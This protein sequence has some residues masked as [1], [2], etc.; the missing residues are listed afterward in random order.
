MSTGTCT[1]DGCTGTVLAD[2]YCDTCGTP[3][4]VAAP[5]SATPPA[6]AATPPPVTGGSCATPDCAGTILD[7]GYC[8]T[9]GTLASASAATGSTRTSSTRSTS[10]AVSTVTGTAFTSGSAMGSRRTSRAST[11]TSSRRTGIGE[12]LVRVPTV[13]PIDPA[14]VVMKDPEVAERKRFCSNCGNK[15]GRGRKDEPGRLSGFCSRCRTAFDFVPKL[16][17]GDLVGGQYEVAGCLAHG[18]LGWIYLA[19]DTAVSGRWVVLKGLLNSG[20][21]AAMA[22]AVAERRF[23]AEVQ[24]PNIVEIYNFATHEGAGYTVMEYV[25]GKSLNQILKARRKAA[26][27]SADPLPVSE[28]IA[29]ML[30][31]APAMSY[32]HDKGLLYCDFKPDNVLQ[33]GDGV[34][35]IDLGGVRRID[36]HSADIYGTVGFQ[37]PEIAEMGPTIASDVFTVGRALAVLTMDFRG[38]TSEYVTTLPPAIDH[39]ALA[40]NDAFHRV[41]QKATAP[42]PDDRFQSIEEL[43]DQLL[44]VLRI[45]VAI[46]SGVPQP[47]P[48]A[49][50]TGAPLGR[51]LPGLS[52]DADDDAAGFLSTLP[53]DPNEAIDTIA[54]G[55][56]ATQ[57]TET[58]ALKLRRID[59]LIDADRRADAQEQIAR[60]LAEDPWEWR[61]V[62]LRGRVR[63]ADGD[64]TGAADDFERCRS[65]A[66]GELA[67]IM[68]AALVDERAANQQR[69]ERGFDLVSSVDRAWIGAAA[70]LARARLRAGDVDGALNAHDRVPETHRE[71]ASAAFAAI[72][73]LIGA[74]RLSE[75]S[76]RAATL[77]LTGTRKLELD[78]DLLDQALTN[79]VDGGA[80]LKPGEQVLGIPLE[81]RAVRLALADR[82]LQLARVTPERARRIELVDRANS[83]RP[84]TV[85]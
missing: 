36:D 24:H 60:L 28:A 34:K 27:D 83:V 20:D 44:G 33:V 3:G 30:A 32:L 10:A 45:V 18:G 26:K 19:Q 23:L 43:G 63:L 40:D 57:V 61:A 7:D 5:P 15:V 59:E 21:D 55:L 77:K 25:G 74:G 85:V 39:P 14:T 31:V 67:P 13:A 8:D 42:H 62:W 58:R 84:L 80:F 81:E 11:R 17:K 78:I 70:G 54:E 2:G 4:A 66:P 79:I 12:G 56:A 72:Q 65:E 76:N 53:D 16:T 50:F 48:S 73:A 9:C 41:L 22:A 68:A 51:D 69:A 49:V 29:Y 75:A 47:G 6:A 52:V 82:H 37:A 38:Y 35:L 46:D 71:H 64:L 1:R